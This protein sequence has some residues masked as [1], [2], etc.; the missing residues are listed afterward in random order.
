MVDGKS[1]GGQ[2][3][4]ATGLEMFLKKSGKY[5]NRRIGL[6]ANQASVS[7]R[8][9]YCWDELAAAG[10]N[11]RRIFS[12]EHGLFSTEQDQVSVK[13]Q[14]GLR[15]DVVSLYGDTAETL[16]PESAALEGIDLVLFDMQDVGS[17]Y[18]TYVNT[19]AL[20]M[21]ALQGKDVE[22][23]VL[24]RPNPLGGVTVEGP[25]LREGFESFV[26]VFSV[27]VRHGLTPAELA[28]FHKERNRLDIRLS[29]TAMKGWRRRM[30]YRDTGLPWVPPSPNMPVPETAR[31][32]PGLCL[33]EGTNL[34]EGRGTTTPF[35]VVGAPFVDPFRYA[36]ALSAFGMDGVHFRPVYFRP[37]F[38][39]HAG[40]LCGGVFIHITDEGFRPF[41]AGVALVKAALECFPDKFEF[42]RDV[43]EFV[44]RHPAFDL[45]A[46]GS[47][48]REKILAGASLHDIQS[49]WQDEEKAFAREKAAYHLYR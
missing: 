12:P 45:L 38:N 33:I 4:I 24:D 42:K 25:V 2:G 20:F 28:L 13:L 19:M 17:R 3:M 47:A 15:C 34:S 18:Y 6:I 29:F 43:Y 11:V 32:Y 9:S 27:P 22:F 35:Q 1:A 40:S 30:L 41:L 16:R 31:L 48:V 46:G 36:A 49:L 14:P 21:S 8:L 39:K 26:G 37:T 10:L 5:R 7:S 23:M 44:T